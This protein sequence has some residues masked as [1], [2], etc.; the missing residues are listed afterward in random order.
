MKHVEIGRIETP[1]LVL[2]PFVAEDAQAMFDNWASDDDV[3]RFLTWPTHS[4]VEVTRSVI[5]SWTSG[6]HCTW[7]IEPREE[8][9]PMGSIGLVEIDEASEAVEVGYCLSKRCWGKGYAAEAL[10]AVN[11][12]IFREM[13]ARRVVAKHDVENPNS[14]KVMRKAG[15]TYLETRRVH[16]GNKLGERDVDV[17]KLDRA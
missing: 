3:T 11:E 8:G 1:R 6:K 13:G 17:Y 16:A 14:G 9:A 4:G 7:C 12:W 5:A 10:R 2:R 15:M